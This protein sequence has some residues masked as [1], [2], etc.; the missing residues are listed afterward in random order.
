MEPKTQDTA[1]RR[2][3]GV[4]RFQTIHDRGVGVARGLALLYGIGT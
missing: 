2:P 3:V 1:E 4:K